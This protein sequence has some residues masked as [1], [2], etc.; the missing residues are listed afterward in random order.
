MWEKGETVAL[1]MPFVYIFEMLC[2]WSAMSIYYKG[3]GKDLPSLFYQE[4]RSKM[5][6]HAG[7]Q[8][9]TELWLPI[10]DKVVKK[11]TRGAK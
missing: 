9:A 11:I 6:L 8:K 1:A 10:F 2:D 3:K 5:L 7:T 4:N